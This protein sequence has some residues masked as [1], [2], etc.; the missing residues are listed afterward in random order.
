MNMKKGR[1]LF[2]GNTLHC[3]RKLTSTI[4]LYQINPVLDVILQILDY[5][6]NKLRMTFFKK[7]KKSYKIPN[8]R[9]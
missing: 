2:T 7:K 8:N 3:L 4:A 6:A 5:K 9:N 1:G